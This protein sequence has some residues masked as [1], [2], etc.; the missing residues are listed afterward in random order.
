VSVIAPPVLRPMQHEDIAWVMHHEPQLYP[1]PWTAGNFTDSIQAGYLCRVLCQEDEPLGYAVM[2]LILD[3]AHLL[4]LSV[5]ASAQGRGLGRALLSLMCEEVRV[6]GAT[7]CFL[8]VRPS[9][10]PARALYE[11]FGFE[12]VGRRRDYY[13]APEGREDAIVMRVAL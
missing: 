9:N 5:I 13:P 1:F 11:R 12:R 10:T 6:F 4:N 7:Q 2:M 8:E 3:E